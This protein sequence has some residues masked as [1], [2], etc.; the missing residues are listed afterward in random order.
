[1]TNDEIRARAPSAFAASKHESRSERYGYIPTSVVIDALRKEGFNPVSAEQSRTRIPGKREFTKHMLRFRRD[2]PVVVREVG[3]TSAEL[4]LINSHDG[5]SAY[6]LLSALFRLAC[7]NGMVA[8]L[9]DLGEVK[10]QHSGDVVSKVIDASYKVI[11]GS[12]LALEQ[13]A[14]W[15]GI[16][17]K[18]EQ[19]IAFATAATALRFD[20]AK[21]PVR[22]TDLIAVRRSEDRGSDLWT[23]FNRAQE[24][25]IR[26]GQRYVTPPSESRRYGTRVQAREVRGIDGNVGLN[27]ALWVLGDEMAKLVTGQGEI[28][29][30]A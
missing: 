7:L 11:D 19:Q 18:P 27:R 30:A 29:A 4:V 24:G 6:Q 28:K 14:K 9:G 8:K 26:G 22:P 12:V 2:N 3:D 5:S 25:L 21:Q 16:D 1:L 13:A 17:L 20:S 15:K 10:V 23:T